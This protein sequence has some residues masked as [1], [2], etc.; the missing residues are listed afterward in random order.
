MAM[1]GWIVACVYRQM[2]SSG[3]IALVPAC[4]LLL[5]RLAMQLFSLCVECKNLSDIGET[6]SG[7]FIVV[8]G[9]TVL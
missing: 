2:M 4:T 9:Y 3:G 7:L 1:A 6:G 8:F 5:C